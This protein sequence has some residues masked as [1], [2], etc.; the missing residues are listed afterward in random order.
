[1]HYALIVFFIATQEENMNIES[2]F[3]LFGGLALFLYGMN[4]MSTNLEVMAGNRMKSILEKLTS[5]RILGVLVG[6]VVTAFVQSSS[7]VTVMVVGFVNSG[8]M[9]LRQAVWIIMGANIGTTITGQLIALDVGLIAPLIAF[10]GVALIVFVKNKKVQYVG[11]IIGGLG[12]LFVGMNLM[13]DSMT[14]LRSSEEFVGLMTQFSNPVIG[15]LVGMIFTAIIQ[16]SSASIG[17]LQTLAASGLIG[18]NGAVF[19]LF[20]QN[21]GTCITAVFASIGTNRNAKRTTLIH[22]L[23]NIIGTAIFVI[24]TLTT[25]FVSWMEGLTPDPVAQIANTHT[26]FNIV[27]TLLLLPFGGY[28]ATLAEKILPDKK[29][30]APDEER[31]FNDLLRTH[32]P[33]GVSTM[34][35]KALKEEMQEMLTLATKNV[36]MSFDAIIYADV[37]H[38]A[39]IE[40]REEEIDLY[41]A[42][43]S[44]RISKVLTLEQSLA[45]TTA[46]NQI[47][48]VIGN[49]ERVGDHAMNLAEFAD[50]LKQRNLK[51]SELAIDEVTE[52]KQICMTALEDLNN[53]ENKD[54]HQIL[55][56]ITIFEQQIDDTTKLYR[57]NQMDRLRRGC[58]HVE[59]S[60][61]YSELLTDYE[62]IGDHLLNIAESYPEIE[63]D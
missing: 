36:E 18:L 13:S 22:L 3:S 16:S 4:M 12:I 27:T 40:A 46:T 42:K 57:Q 26:I 45:D 17:I 58:C 29:S 60:I 39:E 49:L 34:A 56:E 10:I 25:P 37:S 20:G 1:M 61:L 30:A 33:L 44:R 52:M 11:G 35:L 55:G 6:A 31:W 41:N 19:V 5:N 9:T 7:A 48:K 51:L 8:L 2:I 59:T 54:S 62:R 38:L 21:I 32:H 15:I 63:N 47:Y 14:P 50:H 43:L 28:L 23:F 24:L 53:F